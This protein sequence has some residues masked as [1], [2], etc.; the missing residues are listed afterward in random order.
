MGPNPYFFQFVKQ[1]KR[2]LLKMSYIDHVLP[3]LILLNQKEVLIYL[4]W[5]K[6]E[7][8]KPSSF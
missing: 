1:R 5:E 4:D 3:S 6:I 7:R 2:N 8:S